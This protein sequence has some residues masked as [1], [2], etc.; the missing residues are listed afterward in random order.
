MKQFAVVV[1]GILILAIASPVLASSPVAQHAM[2]RRLARIAKHKSPVS[3]SSSTSSSAPAT[4]YGFGK[5]VVRQCTAASWKCNPSFCFSGSAVPASCTLLDQTCLGPT[6]VKPLVPTIDCTSVSPPPSASLGTDPNYAAYL[7]FFNTVSN[8]LPWLMDMAKG[9][10]SATEQRMLAIIQN[11]IELLA[12]LDI[13]VASASY[14]PLTVIEMMDVQ[15]LVNSINDTLDSIKEEQ[16]KSMIPSQQTPA[17]VSSSDLIHQ[18]QCDD[19][20][21]QLATIGPQTGMD[22]SPNGIRYMHDQLYISG[23]L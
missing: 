4:S 12:K 3:S 13:Y 16:L 8:H 9:Y 21:R 19:L 5:T 14:R 7:T 17:P 1:G 22:A 15:S 2:E 20:K 11:Q 10:D 23:C 6:S 18:S